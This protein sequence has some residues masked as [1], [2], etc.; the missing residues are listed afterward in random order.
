MQDDK[1]VPSLPKEIRARIRN[2]KP[3]GSSA[4]GAYC[5]L[6]TDNNF[7]CGTADTDEQWRW[8]KLQDDLLDNQYLLFTSDNK[9]NKQCRISLETEKFYCADEDEKRTNDNFV[10]QVYQVPPKDSWNNIAGETI[11]MKNNYTN[12][13]CDAYSSTCSK[14]DPS[15]HERFALVPVNREASTFIAHAFQ[16]APTS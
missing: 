16:H 7:H 6:R 13:W 15:T 1:C 2:G 10:F 3:E 9:G 4:F 14:N 5:I 8:E 11:R 12:K